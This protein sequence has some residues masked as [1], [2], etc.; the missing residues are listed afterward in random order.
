MQLDPATVWLHEESP[1]NRAFFPDPGN[2]RFLL[3]D[4]VGILITNLVAMGSPVQTTSPATSAPLRMPSAS[5]EPSTS[6]LHVPQTQFTASRK[7]QSTN[8]KIVQASIKRLPNGKME[9]LAQNQT[10]V[11][12]TETTANLHYVS[13]AI[14]R[15]WGPEYILVTSDGLK[16][17]DSSGTQGMLS[18]SHNMLSNNASLWWLHKCIQLPDAAVVCTFVCSLL[19]LPNV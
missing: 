12:V 5:A 14:Q 13:S 8:V 7:A 16:L 19:P 10:F 1:G 11:D 15:K 6:G 2:T 4:D 9:F 17:D 3:N 18:C